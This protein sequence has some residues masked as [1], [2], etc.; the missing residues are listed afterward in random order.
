M[1]YR[2]V[3]HFL[4]PELA[5]P[6]YGGCPVPAVR[7]AALT[8]PGAIHRL[9]AVPRLS[10]KVCIVTGAAGGMGAAEARLFASEGAC[11]ALADVKDEQGESVAGEI[12]TAGGTALYLHH[13]VAS[14]ESWA[15]VT[16]TVVERYGRLD[17]LVNN[18]GI[19]GGDQ[20]PTAL[21][22]ER[23]DRVV[24]VNS[25]GVFLG[26]RHAARAMRV[27]GGGS[28]INISSIYGLIGAP[29]GCVYPAS[30]GAVRSL[31][32]AAAV[33]LAPDG[34]RVNSVHPGFI[35]TPQTSHM[36]EDPE[37]VQDLVARTPL[38]WIAMPEHIAWGVLYLASDES[39]YMTGSEFVI[40]GGISAQ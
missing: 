13:D 38:G 25:T 19:G 36:M 35:D 5:L 2:P 26:I 34:I 12:R 11:V 3:P 20:A 9:A 1:R 14:D 31:T 37:V 10:G 4:L 39:T 22:V 40:D 6:H 30:K 15:R 18:A 27:T 17:V 8:L 33:Q 7:G 21:E 24:A 28:I 32:K 16:D 29:A 23:W